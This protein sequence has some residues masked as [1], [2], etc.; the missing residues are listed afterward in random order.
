MENHKRYLIHLSNLDKSS[1]Y[2]FEVLDQEK[3]CMNISRIEYG[4]FMNEVKQRKIFLT[5][6]MHV[7]DN[8]LYEISPFEIHILMMLMWL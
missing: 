7:C 5:D 8:L 4:Y 6:M 1:N 2:N 3:I